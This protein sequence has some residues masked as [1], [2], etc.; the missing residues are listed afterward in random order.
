MAIVTLNRQ[1]FTS[2]LPAVCMRCGA[3]ATVWK[4]STYEMT[5]QKG[6]V[7]FGT[8]SHVILL[9][10]LGASFFRDRHRLQMPFCDLHQ[11]HWR[12]RKWLIVAGPILSS[13][14]LLS[15][16]VLNTQMPGAGTQVDSWVARI[17]FLAFGGLIT[18]FIVGVIAHETSIHPTEITRDTM[19][20]K[21]VSQDFVKATL[22]YSAE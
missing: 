22:R 14:L 19:T 10:E 6:F 7:G 11:N 5:E 9:L 15:A 16:A 18:S 12:N 4:E 13:L 20:F 2:G 21:G 1:N 17:L 3:P 8:F